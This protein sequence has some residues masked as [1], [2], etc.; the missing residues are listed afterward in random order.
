MLRSVLDGINNEVK[1]KHREVGDTSKGKG[2]KLRGSQ[3]S[4]GLF[5]LLSG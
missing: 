1:V 3:G 2:D 5:R 4:T